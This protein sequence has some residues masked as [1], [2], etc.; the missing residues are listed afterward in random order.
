MKRI[1]SLLLILTIVVIAFSSCANSVKKD[2]KGSWISNGSD[3]YA[4]RRTFYD[5]DTYKVERINLY[6]GKILYVKQGTYKILTFDKQIE[7][8]GEEGK[9]YLFY[10][11]Q[12]DTF[13]LENYKRYN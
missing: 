13:T 11:Y 9:G 12:G 2:L 6:T 4:I 8:N 3:G 7:M 10:E 1:L 5:D